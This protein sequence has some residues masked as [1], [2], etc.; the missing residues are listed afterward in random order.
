[1]E[2]VFVCSAQARV[3]DFDIGLVAT[4]MSVGGILHD[5]PA[6]GSALDSEGDIHDGDL[7]AFVSSCRV[8][9]D[10]QSVLLPF[11]MTCN[12]INDY[13]GKT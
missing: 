5:F 4:Q 12:C 9:V 6:L 2:I 7:M 10:W 1:M 8:I 13:A 11:Q 3:R